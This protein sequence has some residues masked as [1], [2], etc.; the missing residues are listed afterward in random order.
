MTV[1]VTGLAIKRFPYNAMAKETFACSLGRPLVV[2]HGEA[3]R[4]T[5]HKIIF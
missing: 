3:N 1:R 4:W 2:T 5:V